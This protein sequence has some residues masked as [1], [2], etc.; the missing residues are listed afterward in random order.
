MGKNNSGLKR[1]LKKLKGF[2]FWEITGSE[3]S[4]MLVR[5]SAVDF[6]LPDDV[7]IHVV[8]SEEYE[9]QAGGFI[10]PESVGFRVY[11]EKWDGECLHGTLDNKWVFTGDTK[12]EDERDLI[13]KMKQI[14][15]ALKDA[16]Y[17]H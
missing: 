5:C 1:A 13:E 17:S 14:A 12:E 4:Y 16:L 8:V 9:S 11:S 7:Y 2:V 6:D 15:A 10:Q 3:R